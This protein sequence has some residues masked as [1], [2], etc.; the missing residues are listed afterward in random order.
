[1]KRRQYLVATCGAVVGAGCSGS[2]DTTPTPDEQAGTPTISGPEEAQQH[3]ESAHESF[4]SAV[5]TFEEEIEKFDSVEDRISF[6][7][8][9]I[10]AHLDEAESELDEAE[11]TAN[12]EQ[13]EWIDEARQLVSWMRSIVDV[14][15]YFGDGFDE[16]QTGLT[17]WDNDRMDDAADSFAE[18]T[19]YLEEADS[20]LSSAQTRFSDIDWDVFE[21]SDDIDRLE[22]ELMMEDLS[23]IVTDFIYFSD[24]YHYLALGFDHFLT[25]AEA[26]DNE[27]WADAADRFSE[28]Y[29]DFATAHSTISRGEEEAS[30]EFIDDFIGLTCLTKA[31]RDSADHY[32]E[33]AEAAEANDWDRANEEADQA[34]QALER[35]DYEG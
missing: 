8:D 30:D 19:D 1:M 27:R 7:P 12:S 29:E 33:A 16:F 5:D 28:A 13:E 31:F 15:D 24:T 20:E 23:A 34:E 2:S 9:V 22:L 4:V 35:C 3:I 6:R 18:T 14:Y 25:A 17:Y 10:D 11:T 32:Q 26:F 21:D